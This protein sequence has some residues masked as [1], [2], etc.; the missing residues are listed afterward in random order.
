[1]PSNSAATAAYA[2][3]KLELFA[4]LNGYVP[5]NFI[6]PF[7]ENLVLSIILLAVL[8][9]LGLR[10]ERGANRKRRVSMGSQAVEDAVGT[11]LRVMEIVLGVGDSAHSVRGVRRR[12]KVRRRARL[13]SI[14]RP[15]RLCRGGRRWTLHPRSAADLSGDAVAVCA[16]AATGTFWREAREP[17]VYAAGANSSLATLPVTLNALD[18]LGVPRSASTLGACVGTNFNNDGIILYEAN[19]GVVRRSGERG[20]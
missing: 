7:V 12:R 6:T 16:H 19:G 5:S 20:S 2:N 9:G 1:M 14:E 10:E 3:K 4:T 8:L 15:R 18:R 17:V 11:L 13:R